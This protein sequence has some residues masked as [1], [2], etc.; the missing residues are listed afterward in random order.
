MA[1]NAKHPR[2]APGLVALLA[3]QRNRREYYW[4]REKVCRELWGCARFAF[5]FGVRSAGTWGR[6]GSLGRRVQDDVGERW[7]LGAGR[8]I[9]RVRRW[10]GRDGRDAT[11]ACDG[12]MRREHATRAVAG[13]WRDG[14]DG[15]GPVVS[16]L[17]HGPA[18]PGGLR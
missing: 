18:I 14:T 4:L 7:G 2:Y 3:T 13:A 9:R 10:R 12:S 6:G 17:S 8:D 1:T 11:K 16:A 5:G 15:G